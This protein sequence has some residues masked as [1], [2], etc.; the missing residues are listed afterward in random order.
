MIVFVTVEDIRFGKVESNTKSP[1]ALAIA[2]SQGG[3]VVSIY[4]S[5]VLTTEGIFWT[6]ENVWGWICHFNENKG[7][8]SLGTFKFVLDKREESEY[9]PFPDKPWPPF[10]YW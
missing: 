4:A 7:R 5:T 9:F 3:G 6:P 2:R 8:K 10:L 1:V